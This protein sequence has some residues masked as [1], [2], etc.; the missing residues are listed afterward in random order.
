ME[1]DER[2]CIDKQRSGQRR[3]R[4]HQVD[5]IRQTTIKVPSALRYAKPDKSGQATQAHRGSA[6]KLQTD[7]DPGK[8]GQKSGKF[9]WEKKK[10]HCHHPPSP[11]LFKCEINL[12]SFGR[13]PLRNQRPLQALQRP[14]CRKTYLELS[15]QA[16]TAHSPFLRSPTAAADLKTRWMLHCTKLASCSKP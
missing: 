15:D 1:N 16:L 11:S 2:A 5:K 9:A 3:L 6:T 7:R 14:C 12:A 10:L 8:G 13:N 4:S